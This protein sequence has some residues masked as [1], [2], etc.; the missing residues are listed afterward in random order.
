MW[1]IR[2]NFWNKINIVHLFWIWNNIFVKMEQANDTVFLCVGGGEGNGTLVNNIDFITKSSA[3]APELRCLLWYEQIWKS[4][5]DGK[6][7]VGQEELKNFVCTSGPPFSII[8][9]DSFLMD[10]LS[11]WKIESFPPFAFIISSLSPAL[12]I[13]FSAFYLFLSKRICVFYS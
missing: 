1:T 2:A 8:R 5:F 7:F 10:H 6:V 4:E 9:C 3:W 12:V 13:L 11:P